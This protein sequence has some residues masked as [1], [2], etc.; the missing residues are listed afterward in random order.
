MFGYVR[1]SLARLGGLE[2][3]LRVLPGHEGETTLGRERQY[4]PYLRQAMEGN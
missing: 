4:N 3:D 1:P 2:G